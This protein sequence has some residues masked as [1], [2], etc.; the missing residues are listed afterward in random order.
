MSTSQQCV[1]FLALTHRRTLSCSELSVVSTCNCAESVRSVHG[2]ASALGFGCGSSPQKSSGPRTCAGWLVT[3]AGWPVA[4]AE[5]DSLSWKCALLT[6]TTDASCSRAGAEDAGRERGGRGGR[7]WS[8]KEGVW[9]GEGSR[10]WCCSMLP[11]MDGK[12]AA[13]AGACVASGARCAKLSQDPGALCGAGAMFASCATSLEGSIVAAASESVRISSRDHSGRVVSRHERLSQISFTV[14]S[15]VLCRA[16][17]SCANFPH[18]MNVP[19]RE[20]RGGR[21]SKICQAISGVTV[22]FVVGGA[23]VVTCE[24][25]NC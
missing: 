13:C 19:S 1:Q 11:K 2:F 17:T 18:G 15:H 20:Q 14:F 21:S 25:S 24:L 8:G 6:I 10:W 3:C 5:S 4:S 9:R 7:V 12:G 23:N 16:A 22:T